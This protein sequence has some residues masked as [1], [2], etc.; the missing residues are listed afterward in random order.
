[1]RL[2]VL[3]TNGSKEGTY[4]GST[5]LLRKKLTKPYILLTISRLIVE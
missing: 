5:P 1:M 3:T 4:M 2:N